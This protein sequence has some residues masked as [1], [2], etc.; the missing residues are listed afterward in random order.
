LD[1]TT[2]INRTFFSLQKRKKTLWVFLTLWVVTFILYIPAAKAGWVIDASGFLSGL[3][4]EGFWDFINRTHSEDQSFYQLFMLQYYV[5][6]KLWGLNLWMWSLLYITIQSINAYLLFIL[7]RNI[8]TDSGVQKGFAI[9]LCGVLIFTICPHI[10]EVVVCKAYYHYL[11]SFLF[12]LLIMLWAIKYQNQQRN[13]YVLGS[14]IIFIMAGLTLEIFY[15][16]PFF[17]LSIALYYRFALGYNKTVFR[18]TILYFFI[19]Q[20]IMLG[21]YFAAL[22]TTFKFLRPHKI[23]LT[24]SVID[25]IS[26]PLKYIFHIVFLGRYFPMLVKDKI[27]SL[28]ESTIML[29]VFYGTATAVFIYAILRLKQLTGNTKAMLLPGVWIAL[30]IGFL[31]PLAFPGS[32]LL[33]FYDR[34]TY[35]ADGFVYVLLV[36]WL[37]SIL[38]KYIAGLLFCVYAALNLYFTID[39]N[40]LWKHSA[41]INN[42]LL[43]G[44]PAVGNKTVVLLNIPENMKGVPMI[45][46]Q[47]DGEYKAMYEV[48]VGSMPNKIYDAASYNMITM[49]DGAHVT[50]INDSM[51]RVTLNQW[52]AWWWYEGHG[53]KSYENA[54]YK[55]NMAD[56][57]HW[58]ELTLKRP[59]DNYLLLYETGANWKTVDMNKKNQDQY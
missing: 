12:I 54:D 10:S 32:A 8:F 22:Y 37:S 25:Y 31:M 20:I 27:Y 42:R 16:V 5:C 26:K 24:V 46:A 6:Y 2:E 52:G 41:Y 35:F 53:A 34:Y 55:L 33:V 59:A 21:V 19:P 38:N 44:L 30:T 3:K 36:L 58:Y 9:S 50:V 56:P 15:L 7:C 47:P 39:V 28:C 29:V 14:V 17:V 43:N 18:K 57:G 51:I 49:N 48:F 4:H 45:G 23:V 11:Q 13:K 1:N 40:T